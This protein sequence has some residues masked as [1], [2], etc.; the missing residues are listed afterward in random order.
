LTEVL[1]DNITSHIRTV[2]E[3]EDQLSEPSSKLVDFLGRLEGDI[4]VL[5]AG[6]KMGPS[7]VKLVSRALANS[8]MKGKKKI[9][10]ISRFSSFEIRKDL[11]HYGVEVIPVDLLDDSHLQNLPDARNVIFM[12][13]QK[14]GTTG[15]EYNTWATNAYL[16]G[17]VAEKFKNSRIVAFSTGNVYPLVT[18]ESGGATEETLPAPIGEYAQS[19][20][21]AER[22]FE[23]SSRKNNTPVSIIRLNYAVELRYG[24]LHDIGGTVLEGKPID[25]KM[26]W[27]NVIW[28]RDANEIAIRSL[29]FASSP[30]SIFNVTGSDCIPVR[31]I[32]NKFASMFGTKVEFSGSEG[33]LALL[34]NS[35]KSDRIFG[36][37][38][39]TLDQMIKW[40]GDW[41]LV[42][43]PSLNKPTHFQET[44]GKF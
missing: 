12:A 9:F 20:L 10:A 2:Q 40:V 29:E 31:E 1:H 33:R 38:N 11:E 34:S 41:L 21:A 4:T 8:S 18:P 24:V 32:A 15:N 25:L 17:R 28:Q 23:F 39:V 19:R 5:G 35:S 14:F 13:G 26:G 44:E 16:A 7:L 42:G 3:L 37:S 27:V 36:R 22:L 43:G 30:P 6:G